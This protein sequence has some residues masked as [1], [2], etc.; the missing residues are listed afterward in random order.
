MT[1]SGLSKINF[2]FINILS[3][4]WK[5]IVGLWDHVSVCVCVR[6][7]LCIPPI[8]FWTPEPIFMK[9]G[10]YITAPEPNSTA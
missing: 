1:Y 6:A 3:L 8:T 7:C 4:F 5:N 2:F 10:K 9:L